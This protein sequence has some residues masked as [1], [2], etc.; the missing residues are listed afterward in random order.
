MMVERLKQ[1]GT[2]HNSR[3]QLKICVKMEASWAAQV[4][5][6][7]GVKPS[8]GFLLLFAS[9]QTAAWISLQ[10]AGL[11]EPRTATRDTAGAPEIWRIGGVWFLT[12]GPSR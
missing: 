3:D 9:L 10:T 6:Q 12:D 1:A 5:R 4:F 8:G 7:A 11:N 2:S